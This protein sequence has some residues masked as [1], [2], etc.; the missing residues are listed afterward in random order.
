[1]FFFSDYIKFG[2]SLLN[3]GSSTSS[4]VW[5]VQFLGLCF[6]DY[7]LN[8]W[9]WSLLNIDMKKRLKHTFVGSFYKILNMI[10]CPVRGGG[11]GWCVIFPG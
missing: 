6:L 10:T 11:V 2:A 3:F 8:N 4:S 9:T 5:F 7:S 1:M